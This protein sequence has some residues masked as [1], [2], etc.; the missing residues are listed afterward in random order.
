MDIPKLI[1]HD[2]ALHALG[3]ALIA[4]VVYLLDVFL[5]HF[6]LW[7]VL[8]VVVIAAIGKEVYDLAHQDRHTPDVYD[9]LATTLGGL[10]VILPLY[11]TL[12]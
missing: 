3:G 4:A 1:P 10:L 7:L 11:Q 9:A 2:K 12:R 8:A 5:G 6:G